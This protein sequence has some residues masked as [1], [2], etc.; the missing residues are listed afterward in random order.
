MWRSPN[1]TIRNIL[2]GTVFR[3]PIVISNI[4]RLVP[5]WVKP[6]IV[7]RHAFGDQYRCQDNVVDKNGSVKLVFHPD[8]NSGD[9]VQ[10]IHHFKGKGTYLGMFNTEESIIGFARSCMQFALMRGYPLKLST[11]NTILKK[12]DGLF[13]DTFE[14]I[15]EEEF[16]GLYKEAGLTYEHRLIDDMVAQAIKGEGGIVW[17]CKNYD[18]DVQSDIVA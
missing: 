12:Y 14:R 11:K 3:E 10:E 13:K 15:Y 7:G 9:T 18:G 16:S 5:G 6:I 2:N 17:A 4:P 8:D 1:G